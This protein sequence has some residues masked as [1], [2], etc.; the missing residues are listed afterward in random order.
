MYKHYRI[1]KKLK[2][3]FI[4]ITVSATLCSCFNSTE[5][6][7]Q[8]EYGVNANYFIGLKNIKTGHKKEAERFF[9]LAMKDG[10]FLTAKK[11]GLE[12]AQIGTIQEKIQKYK[13]LLQLYKN[14]EEILTAAINEFYTAKEYS[15]II[16]Y[17]NKLDI[18]T[19]DNN[20]LRMRF[21]SMFKK[22]DSRLSKEIYTWYTARDIS[23]EHKTFYTKNILQVPAAEISNIPKNIN[24][25]LSNAIKMNNLV[26]NII[27][28]RITI[29]NKDYASAA[30]MIPAIQDIITESLK[31]RKTIPASIISDLGK[32]SLYS[33][34]NWFS[35]AQFFSKI[36]DQFKNDDNQLS[37]F[38]AYFYAGRLFTKGN[39]YYTRSLNNLKEALEIA[40]ESINFDNALWYFLNIK[41]S[42]S[43][44]EVIPALKTYCTQWHDPY[45]FD[46]FF[47][48]L[49]VLL[50]STHNWNSFY[51]I[52]N[53]IDGYASDETVAK[54]AYIAARLAELKYATKSSDKENIKNLY[55]RTLNSGTDIYYKL[56]AAAKLNISNSELK[57]ILSS[58]G[59]KD[60][61]QNNL[62]T[63]S[64]LKGY[65]DFGFPEK[66][67][68]EWNS[69]SNY[70]KANNISLPQAIKLAKFLQACADSN[71][72]KEFYP[73]ALRIA[74]R[75][76][77]Y[78]D[79][80][81]DKSTFR[82]VYPRDF[83]Q[84]VSATCKQFSLEEYI[85]YALIRSES[86]FD[87]DIKSHAGAVGLTQLMGTTAGDISQKM[88][89]TD[90]DLTDPATNIEF[91]GYYLSEMIQ[92]LDGSIIRAFF[93]YNGG[94]TRVRRW[95]KN[96]RIEIG[97]TKAFPNDLFLETIPYAET[98]EYG[99]KL[100]AACC[101]Y[102]WL[103]YNKKPATII[104]EIMK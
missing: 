77:L 43:A 66:I 99:R 34:I 58:T 21:E 69:L 31:K 60:N 87:A 7:I 27:T 36:A 4:S 56:M 17:T 78:T 96:V 91:G 67:Y 19:A 32:A 62:E 79:N 70:G 42:V 39:Y 73:Q 80:T 81:I 72:I 28:F 10:T 33:N 14:D 5:P 48:S 51:T 13:K 45:Y 102:A 94:L 61:S 82:Q 95:V 3:F 40:P 6:N 25:N 88:H 74:S 30:V 41:L 46:D 76:I 2:I 89:K 20:I 101:M 8:K 103:Y 86:F 68:S 38:Y 44:E 23:S 97:S 65:A 104:N 1:F 85:L 35:S 22:N 92:R 57:T 53:I 52:Y 50:F 29:Y 84:E 18:T 83:S 64:L 98:R 59:R 100:T 37:A 16:N 93:A 90:F 49:S 54:Y 15:L 71:H 75:T 26:Y 24:T 63:E 47:D 9:Q 11:S 12:Y 55:N